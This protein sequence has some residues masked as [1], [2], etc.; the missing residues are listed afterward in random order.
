MRSRRCNAEQTLLKPLS[1]R[2]GRGS[3][4]AEPEELPDH[5]SPYGSIR[6]IVPASDGEGDFE[7]I[8]IDIFAQ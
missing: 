3:D 2:E 6:F 1:D 7:R 5:Q 4:E 8:F